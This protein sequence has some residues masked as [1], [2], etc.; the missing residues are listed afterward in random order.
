MNSHMGYPAAQLPG[1][2]YI[3]S[4]PY[5]EE[6]TCT[7]WPGMERVGV[8]IDTEPLSTLQERWADLQDQLITKIDADYRVFEG[9]TFKLQGI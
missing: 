3:I 4:E 5:T 6:D 7:R 2:R 1:T 9:R 8:P